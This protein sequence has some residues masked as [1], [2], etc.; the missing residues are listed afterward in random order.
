MSEMVER[1]ALAIL[2]ADVESSLADYPDNYR[3]R[4]RTAI[5]AMREPTES[6]CKAGIYC[7]A[8]AQNNLLGEGLEPD[9]MGAAYRAMID[10]AL[11]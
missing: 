3:R 10:E 9:E 6:M 5:Q 4:A 1:V 8:L 11:K 2:R 7:E